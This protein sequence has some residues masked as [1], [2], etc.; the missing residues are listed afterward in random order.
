MIA[1]SVSEIISRENREL[2]VLFA[3]LNGRE[4]IE[5]VREAPPFIDSLKMHLDNHMINEQDFLKTCQYSENLYRLAGLSNEQEERYY[6]PDTTRYLLETVASEF[7]IIIVDSGNKIDNGLAVGA[8]SVAKEVLLVLT[9]QE[10]ALRRFEKTKEIYAGL[11]F[12]LSTYIINK[13]QDMDPY[14][15]KY[16]KERL[17]IPEHSIYN[18]ESAGYSRQAEIDNKTLMEYRNDKF[19]QDIINIANYILLESGYREIKK[20]GKTNGKILSRLVPKVK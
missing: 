12:Q 8:L 13:Y 20:R 5:Y 19:T 1:Q 4:S 3:S 11:G 16:I 10:T 6:F 9:Q 15:I 7:D 18:V 2:K 14:S 17:D